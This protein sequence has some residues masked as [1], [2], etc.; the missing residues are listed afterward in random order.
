V[1]QMPS[2]HGDHLMLIRLR[3]I[4]PGALSLL[5]VPL[6]H[7][8]RTYG[9]LV[10]TRKE[11]AAFAKKEKTLIESVGEDI[12]KALERQSLFDGTVLLSRPFVAQE[13][14]TPGST[15]PESF[16]A[17]PAP[18]SP[19]RE[20]EFTSVLSEAAQVMPYDRAWV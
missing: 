8:E 15:S 11:S 13:P 6:R 20:A 19:E 18:V 10:I 1:A 7:M 2:D 14:L 4:T 16:A 9:V 3:L 12:T 17:P 5:A